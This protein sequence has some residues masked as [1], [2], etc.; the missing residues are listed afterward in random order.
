VAGAAGEPVRVLRGED[1]LGVISAPVAWDADSERVPVTMG[2]EGTTLTI[3]VAHRGADVRYPLLVD[4]S[5]VTERYQW[6]SSNGADSTIEGWQTG[7]RDTDPHRWSLY[8]DRG[9][10]RASDF[11]CRRCDEGNSYSVD[12]KW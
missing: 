12:V 7:Y 2:V 8:W 10:V 11:L 4:P 1:V 9:P 5:V 3:D 6:Y